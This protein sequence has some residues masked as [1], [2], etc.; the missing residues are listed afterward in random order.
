MVSIGVATGYLVCMRKFTEFIIF[1][2]NSIK[3]K[4]LFIE[5]NNS[6]NQVSEGAKK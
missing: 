5:Q 6:D 4:H 3:L 2:K 1:L